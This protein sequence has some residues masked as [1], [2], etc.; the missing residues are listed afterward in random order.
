MNWHGLFLRLSQ[1]LM[2]PMHRFHDVM[3]FHYSNSVGHNM[4]ALG[5][6][7]SCCPAPLKQT[8]HT[9]ISTKPDL[10]HT[11][12][13]P[14]YQDNTKGN[15]GITQAVKTSGNASGATSEFLQYNGESKV[16]TYWEAVDFHESK[17]FPNTSHGLASL[18]CPNSRLF[19]ILSSLSAFSLCGHHEKGFY[20]F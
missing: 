2:Y 10:V 17:S 15:P 5:H 13:T 1:P 12:C 6:A 9:L 8:S 16:T 20:I 11:N 19:T 14:R 18:A 3:H 7:R 4:L